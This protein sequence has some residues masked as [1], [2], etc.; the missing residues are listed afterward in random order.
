MS[1]RRRS[2]VRRRG[3][4][5]AFPVVVPV[6][7]ADVRAAMGRN[8]PLEFIKALTAFWETDTGQRAAALMWKFAELAETRPDVAQLVELV[9]AAYGTRRP[10]SRGGSTWGKCGS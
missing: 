1:G 9:V 8:E 4:V 2:T 5:L 6:T 3:R 7:S 10:P